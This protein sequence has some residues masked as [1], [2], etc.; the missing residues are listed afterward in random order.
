MPNP[1]QLAELF[2]QDLPKWNK[3]RLPSIRSLSV[4]YHAST[5]TVQVAL[6][7]LR[8]HGFIESRPR[9]GLWRVG[10]LPQVNIPDA[11]WNADSHYHQFKKEILDGVHPWDSPLPLIKELAVQWNCHV[12]TVSKVL[13]RAIYEGVLE[14]KGRSHYPARPSVRRKGNSPTILCLGAG[15]PDGNFRMDTDRES[16]FWRELGA[17]AAHA[18]LSLV[19]RVWNGGRIR[20]VENTVG[21]I[22]T[23]WHYEDPR[24]ICREIAKLKLPACV[25]FDE[26]TREAMRA[27]PRLHYH[28]QGHSTENGIILT[29]HLIELGHKHIAFISPWHANSWSLKR[30]KGI[31]EEALRSGCRVDVF[32]L[33]G[34]SEWDRLIPAETDP[35]L[36]KSFPAKVI[37]K[38]VEGSSERIR[39]LMIAELGWNRIRKDMEP[40]F[41][42]AFESGATA[43]IGANDVCALNALKWLGEKGIQVPKQI[44]VAGFDDTIEALRSD[45]TS[46]RFSCASVARSMIYQILAGIKAPTLTRHKGTVVVRGSTAKPHRIQS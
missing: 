40:L 7:I 43:W 44:S 23:N 2:T 14:R 34:D 20:P 21:V 30:F 26:Q 22:A 25:W 38:I 5:K 41:A 37:E 28:D 13:D 8:E 1:N 15:A 42:Q 29:R 45:L 19:R 24:A 6:A 39:N 9:S 36:I 18:G 35:L 3:G 33:F 46:F 10:E 17:Q 27:E 12:Q 31:E 16:D 11:K 32:C 4:Q